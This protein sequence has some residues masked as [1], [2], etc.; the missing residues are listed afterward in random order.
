MSRKQLVALL[1]AACASLVLAAC[2]PRPPDDAELY[3]GRSSGSIPISEG[4]TTE[5]HIRDTLPRYLGIIEEV[6][7][8][9]GGVLGVSGKSRVDGCATKGTTAMDIQW[10]VMVIPAIDYE[11]LRRM[12]VEGAQRNGFAYS[13]D[14]VRRDKLNSRTV[15]VGDD[16][17]NSLIFYHHEAQDR[18]VISLYSG[19][20][21]PS[22][23]LD[24]DTLRWSYPLPSPEEMFPNLTIVRAFDDNG[25]E[26]PELRPQSG[27][28]SGE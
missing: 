2:I 21:F 16:Y 23:P 19:C 18:I 15:A 4:Q 17:G 5:V 9:S 22:Q 7:V 6:V 3:F 25:D 20:M 24:P 1:G 12:V 13:W 26:N 10:M 14:P 28:Q 11:D 8:E 27:T